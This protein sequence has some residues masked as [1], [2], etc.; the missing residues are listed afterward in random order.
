MKAWVAVAMSGG[1]DSS[2]AAAILKGGGHD[3]VGVTM[4][5]WGEGGEANFEAAA[6][7]C[8]ML[9]IEH[10]VI[11]L[12]DDFRRSVIEYFVD[13][14]AAGLTPNPCVRCNELVKFGLLMDFLGQGRLRATRLATGHYARIAQDANTGRYSLSR[15]RDEGK[16]Q[17]Y[18]LY[19][20][21][22]RQ[23]SAALFPLGDMTKKEVRAMASSMGLPT[24]GRAESQ[25]ICFIPPEGDY[26]GFVEAMRPGTAKEGEFVDMSGAVVGRHRGVAFYTI[27]QRKGLGVSSPLGRRYVIDRDAASGRVTLGSEADLNRAGC[28]VGDVNWAS[29]EGL[30]APLTADVKLRYR[31]RPV[32]AT[33]VPEDGL[34][35]VNFH[36]PEPGVSPGQ[37]AVFYDGDTVLGG[38]I[39]IKE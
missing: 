1:V 17:S 29:V 3:V 31:F 16:D 23:L 30:T 28:L 19:R 35:R 27:G 9:G 13:G 33:L 37:S 15:A 5:L 20:L 2:V 8:D 10:S 6:S 32:K 34:L 24:A 7:V 26:R 36:N 4:R 21:T 38:G 11:D 12:R 14:Y 25:E 22:Q 39:I 18:F